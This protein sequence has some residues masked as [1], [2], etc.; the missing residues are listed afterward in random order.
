MRLKAHLESFG[1]RQTFARFSLLTLVSLGLIACGFHLR[2]NIPLPAGLS[3]MY[4]E[5]DSPYNPLV[6]AIKDHLTA[7]HITLADSPKTANTVLRIIHIET[8]ESL[9]S[10]SASTNTRQYALAQTLKMELMGKKGQTIVP[11]SKLAATN[12]F[13]VESSQVLSASSQKQALVG[14]MQQALVMQLMAK[15]ASQDAKHSLALQK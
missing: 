4:I 11:L 15:L 13:T 10:V 12:P 7:Y 14:D 5:T 2:G 3:P 6:Q 1:L 9:V 8:S